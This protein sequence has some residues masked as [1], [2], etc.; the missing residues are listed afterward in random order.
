MAPCSMQK[1]KLL[2]LSGFLLHWYP[3]LIN[4][5]NKCYCCCHSVAKSCLTLQPHGLQ[6][7]RLPCPSLSLGVSSDSCPLCQRCHPTISSS[8]APFS[9]CPQSF[10][11]SGSL[12]VS[13]LFASSGPSTGALA[14]ATVLLMNIQG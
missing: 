6:H 3:K 9:S 4:S 7:A 5:L 2:L 1:Q 12:P 14:S 8:T 11:A 10:P 13:Q